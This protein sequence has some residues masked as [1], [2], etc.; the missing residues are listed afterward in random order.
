MSAENSKLPRFE[1]WRQSFGG[2]VGIWDYAAHEGGTTLALAFASLFWPRLVEVE[3]C[4]LLAENLRL[5]SFRQWRE[6]LGDQREA[7]E[8]TVN[9]VHLWDL[10]HPA[11]EDVPASELDHLADVLGATWRVALAQQFPDRTGEV[12][13]L[14]DGEDYGPTITLFTRTA[15]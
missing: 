14:R 3:G 8:R 12:V 2:S 11:S 10:F 15:D 6:R 4:V 9:H 5:T 7:I 1:R 13:V